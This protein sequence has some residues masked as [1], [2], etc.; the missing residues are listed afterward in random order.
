MVGYDRRKMNNLEIDD[1][2]AEWLSFVER[3]RSDPSISF[4][5]QWARF[6]EL[7]DARD[8]SL[9]RYRPGCLRAGGSMHRTSASSWPSSALNPTTSSS[10][11]SVE[12]RADFWQTV[13]DR[14][15]IVLRPRT[16]PRPRP[17]ETV[18]PIPRWLPGARLN[19][20]DSCFP[21][22]G[23]RHSPSSRAVRAPRPTRYLTYGEL[24]ILVNR[25]AHGLRDHGFEPGARIA[26]YMPMTIECVAAYLGIVR[27]GCAVISIADSFAPQEVAPPARDRRGRRHHHRRR[28]L[29][30]RPNHRSL[31]QD[32]RGIGAPGHRD[33]R[34][35][36]H[37]TPVARRRSLLGRFPRRDSLLPISP[38]RAR[39]P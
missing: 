22:R 4:D 38:G 34:P 10:R 11:W 8:P 30:R 13:I 5:E 7:S 28:V 26:L 9:G 32:P 15:G 27:A 33:R 21:A 12:H 18:P 25:V 2:T 23:L 39:Q 6:L 35:R 1:Q 3:V 19:I 37:P 20:T 29:P 31:R 24:E 14:L 16:G 17:L 36:G